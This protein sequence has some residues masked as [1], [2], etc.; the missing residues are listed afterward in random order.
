MNSV[1]RAG[2][3]MGVMTLG[4][5]L[6]VASA[7]A[8]SG[9]PPS[10]PTPNADTKAGQKPGQKPA[11]VPAPKPGDNDNPFP[12]E[13]S[14]APVIPVDE[15]NTPAS[16]QPARSLPP[17]DL[18]DANAGARR[19]VDA[20]G[21]P[22]LSPEDRGAGDSG[23]D[24]GFSSSRSGLTNL[25]VED[26]HEVK[27]GSSVKAKTRSQLIKEDIDVGT[28]YL[29]KKNWKAAQLRFGHAY[30]LDPENADAIF[31]LAE[32]ERHLQM[33]KESVEHYKTFLSYDSEGP[34]GK[35]ARK[36]L[37]EAEAAQART[38]K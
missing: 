5:G 19:P 1:M 35:A 37:D 3:V 10:A 29:E 27:P 22:V 12:G 18:P 21:D 30:S 11:E 25:P 14:N 16:N 6:A 2:L 8:Q 28:L 15:P 38:Q 31:E 20:D 24:D 26:D 32:A 23:A 34:H 13:N 36:G 4:A 17:A 9:N 7:I 33:Y